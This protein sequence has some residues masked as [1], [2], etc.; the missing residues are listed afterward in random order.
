MAAKLEKTRTPGIFKRGSRYVFSYRVAGKQRWESSRTLDEARSNRSERLTDVRRGE[1]QRSTVK[2]RDYAPDWIDRYH[3]T[4]RRGFTE[5]TRRE[6]RRDLQRYIIPDLGKYKLGEITPEHVAKFIAWLCDE[7][8]QRARAVEERCARTG[9]SH[10]LAS[11]RLKDNDYRLAD[12]TVRRVLAPLRSCLRTAMRDGVIRHNPTQGA[13]LPVR[14]ED[15]RIAEG[16]DDLGDD[17]DVKALRT[18]Q[19]YALLLVAPV[20]HRLLFELLAATGLRISEA[21]ALRWGDVALDGPRPVVQVRRAYV[22]GNFKA[23][24]SR[25]G[26]REVPIDHEL[27]RML[28][29]AGPGPERALVF[30]DEQ[31]GPLHA[32]NLLMRVF[33]PAAE[34]AGVPWAG[35]HTLRH[36][37]ATMLFARGRNAVQVQRW[38]GHHSA[39]FTLNTYIELLDDDL[40][41]PLV[42]PALAVV[43]RSTP[44]TTKLVPTS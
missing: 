4:G 36:T 35:F 20:R 37:C 41:T 28:R 26:R 34:E 19:L 8:A 43:P 3:G 9:E 27:V 21:L 44:L 30:S 38:L 40:G 13:A 22:R 32:S 17:R 14:D 24:K 39:A 2:L 12:A 29:R 31:G 25:Y 33:K 6:Y 7:D 15:R 18:E 10:E 1:G 16:L 42:L 5:E 11:K 23:P